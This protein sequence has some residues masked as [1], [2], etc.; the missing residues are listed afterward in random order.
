MLTEITESIQ[1]PLKIMKNLTK[2]ACVED[3][4]I[5]LL[6]LLVIIGVIIIPVLN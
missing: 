3:F 4:C 6:L 5:F 1:L 2:I